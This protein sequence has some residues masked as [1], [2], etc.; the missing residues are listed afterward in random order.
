[1][2]KVH[3]KKTGDVWLVRVP[4]TY[5]F[6]NPA[7]DYFYFSTLSKALSFAATAPQ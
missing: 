7:T 6:M 3:I 1:M 2:R 5:W 4:T